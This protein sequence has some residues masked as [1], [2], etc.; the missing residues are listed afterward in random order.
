MIRMAQDW[1]EH[2]LDVFF[3]RWMPLVIVCFVI[4]IVALFGAMVWSY[5]LRTPTQCHV[6]LASGQAVT[7]LDCEVDQYRPGRVVG[8]TGKGGYYQPE[9]QGSGALVCRDVSYAPGAWVS[10]DCG[11]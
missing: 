5:A 2:V 7:A 6:Q 3:D 10:C 9:H 8:I 11:D 4:I 1:A